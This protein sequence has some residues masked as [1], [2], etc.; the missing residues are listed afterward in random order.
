MEAAEFEQSPTPQVD[1]V[2]A[3]SIEPLV[4][5]AETVGW[6]GEVESPTSEPNVSVN[7]DSRLSSL[8]LTDP[9]CRLVKVSG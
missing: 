3:R 6:D 1:E 8:S 5:S 2:F 4:H 9:S 7:G